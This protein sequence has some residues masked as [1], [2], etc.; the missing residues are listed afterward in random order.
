MDRGWMVLGGSKIPVHSED[1]SVVNGM[2]L[3]GQSEGTVGKC[4]F[5]NKGRCTLRNITI[6][7]RPVDNEMVP[8]SGNPVPDPQ[9]MS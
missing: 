9:S 8:S 5:R 1:R 7:G 2:A 6:P 3:T 4:S